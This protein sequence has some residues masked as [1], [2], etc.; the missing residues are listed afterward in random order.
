MN[1]LGLAKSSKRHAPGLQGVWG[2]LFT[3]GAVGLA[4]ACRLVL[5]QKWGDKLPYITFFVAAIMCI[6]LTGTGPALLAIISGFILANWFFIPPRH[7]LVLARPEHLV[8]TCAYLLNLG[9]V[10]A[11]ATRVRRALERERAHSEALQLRSTELETSEKRFQALAEAAFEGI[12]LSENGRIIDCNEQVG[13]LVGYKR[14]ELL[15]KLATDFIAPEQRESVARNIQEERPA[16]YELDLIGKDGRRRSVEAHGRPMRNSEGKGLRVSVVRDISDQKGREQAL[17]R[18]AALIDLSPDATF[19]REAEGKIL[20][21]SGGAENLYGWTKEEALGRQT[22]ELLQARLPEPLE[23]IYKKLKASGSWTGELQHRTKKGTTVTVQSRWLAMKKESGAYE[24]LESN[25]DISERKRWEEMMRR[26][27]EELERLM[28]A[29]PVAV[30]IAHD[31]DCKMI[32]GNRSANELLGVTPGTNVSQS[33]SA[34]GSGIQHYKNDGT[35]YAAEEL[36][37]QRAAATGRPVRSVEVEF[38]L[39]DGKRAWLLGSAEPLF[40][41]AGICRGAVAAFVDESER[42]EA[43]EALRAAR[44]ELALANQRLE[45]GVAER[46]RSLQEK[47]A[48]LNA[49]CYTLAHDFRSPLRTQVGFARILIEDYGEKLGAEGASH[50]WRVLQAAQRQSDIIQD[51]LAH[52]SVTRTELPLEPVKLTE[53]LEQAQSDLALELQDKQAELDAKGINELEIVM[54]NRSSLHLILLNLL[55]NAFKFIRPGT[56]PIVRLRTERRGEFVRLWV[57]DNGIGIPAADIGK[58]FS[59]FQRLNA[60]AYPGTGMG[61]AIVKK[62][63]ERMGGHVGVESDSGKGSRFWVDIKAA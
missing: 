27:T 12:L 54:A 28:D 51:L 61:L 5:D 16:A 17:R 24:I 56:V 40:D 33:G 44:D 46:T 52:I 22:A 62:A 49:F 57:E 58:L 38:R 3:S 63:I 25:L 37:L 42:K 1:K 18:Q 35:K 6:G 31:R 10:L 23:E 7:S 30:W 53:A 4:F 20:F 45:L 36:P 11:F 29:L 34:E 21:W 14:E 9:I 59:M 2:Y 39:T 8:M 50:A 48:E 47:T 26:R 43:E 60:N 55:T 13:A 19:V 32:T 41:A 15:G